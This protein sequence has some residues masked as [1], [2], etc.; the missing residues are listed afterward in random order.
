M[1]ANERRARACTCTKAI[2][3]ST[4]LFSEAQLYVQRLTSSTNIF[5]HDSLAG[6]GRV[7]TL[8]DRADIFL[9]LEGFDTPSLAAQRVLGLRRPF[10][11]MC[12]EAFGVL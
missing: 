9:C 5:I 8:P 1:H 4:L 10:L 11:K 3:H 2:P 7:L 12:T 6:R